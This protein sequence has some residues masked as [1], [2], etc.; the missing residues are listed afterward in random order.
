MKKLSQVRK[1]KKLTQQVLAD[2]AGISRGLIAQ[3]ECG[4]RRFYPSLRKRL[5]KILKV[6]EGEL[7]EG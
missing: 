1:Q 7:V 2:R 3:I 5:A 6:N 4:H